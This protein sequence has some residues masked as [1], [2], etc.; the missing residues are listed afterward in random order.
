MSA[1]TIPSGAPA[2]LCECG[3]GKPVKAY[4]DGWRRYRHAH[5]P[6]RKPYREIPTAMLREALERSGL[7]PTDV[8]RSLGWYVHG[9][10]DGRRVARAIGLVTTNMGH[11]YG[12]K[13]QQTTT[14]DR[15]V[16]IIR[17]MGFDPVDFD[18]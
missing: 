1:I 13:R 6:P 16:A 8:A 18:L 2:P 14:Y 10:A 15:A 12:H 11:G 7:T 5:N 9:R 3:C 4:R 17:A